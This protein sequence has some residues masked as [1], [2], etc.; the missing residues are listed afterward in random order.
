MPVTYL[1]NFFPIPL[2]DN[3]IVKKKKKFTNFAIEYNRS[4]N[5]MGEEKKEKKKKKDGE[6]IWIILFL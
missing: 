2:S 6:K 3:D 5:L 1:S 4:Y